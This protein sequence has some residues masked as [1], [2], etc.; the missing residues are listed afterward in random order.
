MNRHIEQERNQEESQRKLIRENIIIS[1]NQDISYTENCIRSID[2][3][4]K[5]ANSDIEKAF[6]SRMLK[7]RIFS[8]HTPYLR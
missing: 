1:Q 3:T 4:I 6:K 7:K 2:E 5:E 8:G